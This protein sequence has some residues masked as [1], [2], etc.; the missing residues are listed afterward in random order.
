MVR[1]LLNV[2]LVFLFM[3]ATYAQCENMKVFSKIFPEYNIRT[4]VIPINSSALS[5]YFLQTEICRYKLIGFFVSIQNDGDTAF[6]LAR[7]YCTYRNVL[8]E[9][10]PIIDKFTLAKEVEISAAFWYVFTIIG[11]PISENLNSK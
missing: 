10:L 11:G 1:T 7:N 3:R 4:E 6:Q 2:L 9:E 8:G 5:K